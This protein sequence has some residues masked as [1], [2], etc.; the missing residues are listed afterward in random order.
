MVRRQGRVRV[1]GRR[2]CLLRER[3]SERGDAVRARASGESAA[4]R[5]RTVVETSTPPDRAMRHQAA[6]TRDDRTYVV[7]H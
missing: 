4:A 1:R 6:V 5:T 3:A 2:A 7:S